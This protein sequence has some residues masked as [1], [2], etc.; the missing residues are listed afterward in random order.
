MYEGIGI[1]GSIA[2]IIAFLFKDEAKI[3]IADS[4][5][6]ILFVVYGILIHS[7][8]NVL[9]NSALIVVQII[10]LRRLTHGKNRKTED[11]NR[12]EEL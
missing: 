7:L 8:S 11:R 3:R 2:I 5:G 10:N 9:L 12:Q 1:A 6:A 4:I